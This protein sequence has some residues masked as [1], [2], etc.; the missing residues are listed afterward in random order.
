M[1]A[2]RKF[3]FL[4]EGTGHAPTS[5]QYSA[6]FTLEL[7]MGTCKNQ[8]MGRLSTESL[9]GALAFDARIHPQPLTANMTLL[10]L[11]GIRGGG[12]A[13]RAFGSH[14][15]PNERCASQAT[16]SPRPVTLGKRNAGVP[17]SLWF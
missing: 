9:Y 17:A 13:G 10:Y 15:L 3:T 16:R 4:A 11:D 7:G 14:A 8:G 6:D 1:N 2:T 12:V 5:W